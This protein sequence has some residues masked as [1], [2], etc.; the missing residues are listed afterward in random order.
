MCNPYNILF[1]VTFSAAVIVTLL[2]NRMILSESVRL[3]LVYFILE[4]AKSNFFIRLHNHLIL[5]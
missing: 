3:S 4:H 2:F 5:N 1:L